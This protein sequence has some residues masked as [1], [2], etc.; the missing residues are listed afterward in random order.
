MTKLLEIA[1]NSKMKYKTEFNNEYIVAVNMNKPSFQERLFVYKINSQELVGSYTCSHGV[2]S[3]DENNLAYAKYFSNNKT[4][5]QTSLGAMVTKKIYNTKYGESLYLKGLENKV[6]SN[7]EE[8]Q[9]VLHGA[10]YM[11]NSYIEKFKRAGFS[12][13]NFALDHTVCNSLLTLIKDNVFMY[14]HYEE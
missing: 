2:N 14:V 11:S 13:G 6:N 12:W 3:C 7:A 4:G 10:D 1:L 5:R 8:R 9:I